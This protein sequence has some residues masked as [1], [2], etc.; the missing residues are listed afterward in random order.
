VRLDDP[1]EERAAS[2]VFALPV[3]DVGSLALMEAA[4]KR[5]LR[6]AC[7]VDDVVRAAE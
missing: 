6:I 3:G 1:N 7:S 5:V 4:C 2:F